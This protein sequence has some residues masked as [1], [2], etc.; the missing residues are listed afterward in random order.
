MAKLQL[1]LVVGLATAAMAPLAAAMT[2][3]V[4]KLDFQLFIV[5][6][7]LYAAAK[8]I[9]L[10]PRPAF[11]PA[12]HWKRVCQAPVSRLLGVIGHTGHVDY[13]HG[14]ISHDPSIVSLG[15]G[16]ALDDLL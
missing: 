8:T 12:A 2:R 10:A 9:F 1:L 4:E 15:N 7:L 5:L 6:V 3:G 11:A 13:H 16:I 14:F